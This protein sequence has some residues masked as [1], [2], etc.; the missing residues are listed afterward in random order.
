MAKLAVLSVKYKF[1]STEPEHIVTDGLKASVAAVDAL[2]PKHIHHPRR[3]RENNR[4]EN[5]HLPVRKRE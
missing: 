4:V 3:L 5:S 2:G 1:A